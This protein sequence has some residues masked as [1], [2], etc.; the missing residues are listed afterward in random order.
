MIVMT[1][2][3]IPLLYL[4]PVLLGPDQIVLGAMMVNSLTFV[5]GAVLGQVWLWVRLGNLRSRRVLG[6][7]MFTVGASALGI[8]AAVLVGM[9]VPDALG[10]SLQAWLKLVV[11][12][13]VGVGVSFGVLAALKV[14]E[15]SPVTTRITRLLRR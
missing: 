7:I 6:V 13:L 5:V 9:L 10:D 8:V 3:K 2:V 11:Q 15:L 12:G 14:D 4:C 1:A